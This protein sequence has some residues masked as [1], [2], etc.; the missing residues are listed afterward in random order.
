[1]PEDLSVSPDGLHAASVELHEHARQLTTDGVTTAS[2]RPSSAGA[3]RLATAIE[4]FTTAYAG[5]LVGHGRAVTLA[6]GSYTAVDGG[7]ATGI[8]AVSV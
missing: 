3:T 7:A 8:S 2:N 1:V 5:R 4:A 6:A